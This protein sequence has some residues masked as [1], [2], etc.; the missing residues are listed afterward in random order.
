MR[1]KMVCSLAL[2]S[3]VVLPLSSI[4]VTW[5]RSIL[6]GPW[7]PFCPLGPDIPALGWCLSCCLQCLG[8]SC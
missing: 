8:L 2:P 4:A 7:K 6:Q 1:Q 5:G 3:V